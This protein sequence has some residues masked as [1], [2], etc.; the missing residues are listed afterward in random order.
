MLLARVPE[1][2]VEQI[3]DVPASP[4]CKSF[5]K[6]TRLFSRRREFLEVAK[7]VLQEHFPERNVL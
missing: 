2:A 7:V 1:R 5:S 3:V 4:F 6:C